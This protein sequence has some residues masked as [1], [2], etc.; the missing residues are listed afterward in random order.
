MVDYLH[1]Y[2]SLYTFEGGAINRCHATL[3]RLGK[4]RVSVQLN[5]RFPPPFPPPSSTGFLA[6]LPLRRL[7][8]AISGQ[9]GRFV[10]LGGR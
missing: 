3:V 7:L 6:S 1:I 4:M 9:L 10:A 2:I 5:R 8:G